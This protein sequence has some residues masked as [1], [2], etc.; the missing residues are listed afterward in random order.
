MDDVLKYQRIEVTLRSNAA[1]AVAAKMTIISQGALTD[2]FTKERVCS[3]NIETDHLILGTESGF[4]HIINFS[5]QVVKSARLHKRAINSISVD[6]DGD[7][8]I[9]T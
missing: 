7:L 8:T 9:L 4:L 3:A 6:L 5:G 2:L 1:C